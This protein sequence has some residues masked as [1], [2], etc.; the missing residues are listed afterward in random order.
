[1]E[2]EQFSPTINVYNGFVEVVFSK[3]NGLNERMQDFNCKN[4]NKDIIELD[5]SNNL[6]SVKLKWK[7]LDNIYPV[8]DK[9]CDQLISNEKI[10]NHIIRAVR[11]TNQKLNRNQVNIR[12]MY[13]DEKN[14]IQIINYNPF[15]L[16]FMLFG[17]FRFSIS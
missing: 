13:L 10:F 15:V 16:K 9:F 7:W 17:K 4:I 14:Q 8:I 5:Y 1:M 3:L 2:E 6:I 11:N 12:S